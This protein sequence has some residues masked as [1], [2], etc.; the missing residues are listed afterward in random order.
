[1]VAQHDAEGFGHCQNHGE[2]EAVC[3]KE[4]SINFISFLNKDLRTAVMRG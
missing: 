2:C 4:I 3:P 1:M